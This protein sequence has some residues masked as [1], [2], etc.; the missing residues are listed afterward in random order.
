MKPRT[1][2]GKIRKGC[3][4]QGTTPF[5]PLFLA[6][7]FVLLWKKKKKKTKEGEKKA[8][9]PKWQGGPF[10]RR[11]RGVEV[12]AVVV[13]GLLRR[14]VRGRFTGHGSA[15]PALGPEW[16]RNEASRRCKC[17]MQC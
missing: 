15:R 13:E 6:D 4:K 10:P 7:P 2:I 11:Q 8:G 12:A 16:A 14:V 17:T 9:N 3:N 5:L 1:S